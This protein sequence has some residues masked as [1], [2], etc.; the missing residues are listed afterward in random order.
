VKHGFQAS[1]GSIYHQ[2]GTKFVY[3]LLVK[4]TFLGKSAF[5]T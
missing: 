5:M 2:W 4:D 3:L 1:I